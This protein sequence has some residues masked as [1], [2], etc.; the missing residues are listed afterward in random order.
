MRELHGIWPNL[1][2]PIGTPMAC[3]V[4]NFLKKYEGIVIIRDSHT[5]K[6]LG[7]YHFDGDSKRMTLQLAENIK[8]IRIRDNPRKSKRIKCHEVWQIKQ[9]DADLYKF[10]LY[11]STSDKWSVPE[12][13]YRSQPSKQ[14][15]MVA[16]ALENARQEYV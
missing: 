6:V 7:T 10:N 8:A 2:K 1:D 12:R 16:F 4:L 5:S 14:A 3:N 11:L 13:E 9:D 15:L